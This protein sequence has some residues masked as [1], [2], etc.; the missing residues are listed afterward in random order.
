MVSFQSAPTVSTLKKFGV[1]SRNAKAFSLVGDVARKTGL[2][3]CIRGMAARPVVE[4]WA[5]ALSQNGLLMD[6][7][8]GLIDDSITRNALT[9]SPTLDVLAILDA[10]LSALDIYARPLL[11]VVLK[12][13]VEPE[14]TQQTTIFF[15]LTDSIGALPLPKTFERISVLINLDANYDFNNDLDE[16]KSDAFDPDDGYLFKRIWRPAANILRKQIETFNEDEQKL[17]FPILKGY[18]L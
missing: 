10:N 18:S 3:I 4:G 13:L 6:S 5:G 14:S 16:L 12:R 15:A 11:D 7:T 8:I 2:I 17:I 1:S 9:K